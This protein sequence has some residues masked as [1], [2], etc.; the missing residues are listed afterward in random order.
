M[1][2][3]MIMRLVQNAI[4]IDLPTIRT[5]EMQT[6]HYSIKRTLD[7]A[8]TVSS[9]IQ[10]HPYSGHFGNKFVDSLAKQNKELEA[11]YCTTSTLELLTHV[12]LH[13]RF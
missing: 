1:R 12:A 11:S 10:T 7:M 9:P 4:S 6:T 5:P 13:H 2:P 3:S 8:P